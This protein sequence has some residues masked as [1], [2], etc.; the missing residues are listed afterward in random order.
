MVLLK[1][2]D[3]HGFVFYTN[4]ESHKGREL[5]ANPRA[6]LVFYWPE[7]HRQVRV[8]GTVERVTPEESDA[9]FATRPR[10][11]RIAARASDQSRVLE[12][13]EALERRVEEETRAHNGGEVSRPEVWGGFRVNP[14]SIEFW[15]G[16]RDRLH[17]R[18]RYR[19][20]AHGGWELERLFP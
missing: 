3:E 6:A 10:G 5:A 12:S 17:D 9:Y 15:Q 4:Y 2:V 19:R 16:R 1:G 7:L 8:E 14:N 13:R 11:S 18:L 20:N